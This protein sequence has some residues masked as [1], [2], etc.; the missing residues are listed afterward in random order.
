MI[1][2]IAN[3]S[4]PEM[5]NECKTESMDLV[6][7]EPGNCGLGSE[8]QDRVGLDSFFHSSHVIQQQ[9]CNVPL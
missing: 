2:K 5:L 4:L 1:Y 9:Q 6:T 3:F 7:D 8:Y